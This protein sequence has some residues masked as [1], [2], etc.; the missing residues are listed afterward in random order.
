MPHEP[1]ESAKP[2]ASQPVRSYPP[3]DEFAI[4]TIITRGGRGRGERG[5]SNSHGRGYNY[6][7][8]ISTST[9]QKI[10]CNKLTNNVF[11]HGNKAAADKMRT[12]MK[13]EYNMSVQ[14]MDNISEMKY[15]IKLL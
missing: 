8:A 14:I 13:K 1:I 11:D 2:K 5:R 7:G 3:Y 9:S 4:A 12:S 6:T 10:L 15:R